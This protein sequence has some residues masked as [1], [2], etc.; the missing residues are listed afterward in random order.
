VDP[1]KT[2]QDQKEWTK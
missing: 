2:I 1:F